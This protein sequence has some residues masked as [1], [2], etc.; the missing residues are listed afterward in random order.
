MPGHL[1]NIH[2]VLV[3]FP[4][5]LLMVGVSIRPCGRFWAISALDP[6]HRNGDDN[7]GNALSNSYLS[8]R[9]KSR[10][11]SHKSVSSD[12]GGTGRARGLGHLHAAVLLRLCYSSACAGGVGSAYS[13]K[14]R[15]KPT[16]DRRSFDRRSGNLPALRNWTARRAS[17]TKWESA[18]DL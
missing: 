8:D 16:P 10:R 1:P 12:A 4:L 18:S 9:P 17:S 11:R 15:W 2:P 13:R 6:P 3:H 5:A 14:V 7:I